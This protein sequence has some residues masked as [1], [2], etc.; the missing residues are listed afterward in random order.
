[1]DTR[2]KKIV[3]RIPERKD[4]LN[5]GCVQN[6]IIHEKLA[7]KGNVFGIDI[8][9]S[10][11]ERMRKRGFRVAVMDAEHLIF[12]RKF[13]FIIAGEL[14][15]HLSNPGLFLAAARKHL[16]KDG[17]VVLTT[18]NISSFYLYFSVLLMDKT[19]DIT[20]VNYFDLKNLSILV[21]RCNL[22]I[23]KAVYL[24]PTIKFLGK[25]LLEK[26]FFLTSVLVANLTFVISKRLSGS[27][28]YLELQKK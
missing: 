10:G 14:I 21:A 20:H 23:K 11:I 24:P 27:Y 19:Q 12:D 18:P 5:I 6:Q 25:N 4:V 3:Y 1:M 15:E 7:E 17:V 9:R 13:D 26:V 8:N 22:K 16:K 28:I 2:I